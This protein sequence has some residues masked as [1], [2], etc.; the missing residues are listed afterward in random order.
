MTTEWIKLNETETLIPGDIVRFTYKVTGLTYLDAVAVYKIENKLKGNKKITVLRSGIPA[1]KEDELFF[2]I[3]INEKTTA[4]LDEV[5]TSGIGVL[6]LSSIIV[7]ALAGLGIVVW[8]NLKEVTKQKIIEKL[9]EGSSAEQ[10]QAAIGKTGIIEQ[11]GKS[12][13]MIAAAIIGLIL[14]REYAK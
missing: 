11:L 5:Y 1:G 12:G 14:V 7:G 13:F 6:A 10:I 9:P 3:K 2:E 4:N 8:L